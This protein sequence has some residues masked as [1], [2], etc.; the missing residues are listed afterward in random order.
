[1]NAEEASSVLVELGDG[2]FGIVTDRDL[3]SRVVAGRLSA[4]DPVSA[5]MSV[6]VVGVGADQT[7]ADVML[8]MLDHD[9]RHVPVFS[10]PGKALGVI[11]AID[12]VAAETSSPFVL[13][14]AIARARNKGELQEAAGRLR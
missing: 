7:G 3:R 12:L 11:V 1:M 10:G 9:I 2:E 4:D 14:R 5:A 8:T 6:P 13:R